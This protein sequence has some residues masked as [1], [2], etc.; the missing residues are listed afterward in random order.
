MGISKLA[1]GEKRGKMAVYLTDGR[2][3]LV[4]ISL[5]PDI[6]RMSRAQRED[7]MVLDDQFFT[8][9]ATSRIYSLKDVLHV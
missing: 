9:D 6:K 3:V 8:F 2:E 4:P 7:W 1:F 5:F